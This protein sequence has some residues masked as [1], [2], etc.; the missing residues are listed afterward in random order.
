MILQWNSLLD[1]AEEQGLQR[2]GTPSYF[3]AHLLDKVLIGNIGDSQDYPKLREAAA[4]DRILELHIFNRYKEIYAVWEAQ[5][6]VRYTD[7]VHC[8][9]ER[10]SNGHNVNEDYSNEYCDG[11]Y[12]EYEYELESRYAR[13][14]NPAFDTLITR[15]YLVSDKDSEFAM[16]RIG[17]TVLF[18]LR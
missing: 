12:V 11:G 10:Y 7:L 5:Q 8:D 2:G 18:G 16:P 1:E 15:T 6:V 14:R 13:G 3:I 17:R 4:D 9:N